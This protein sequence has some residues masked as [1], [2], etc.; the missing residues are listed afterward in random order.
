[1]NI[2]TIIIMVFMTVIIMQL[3]TA[4]QLQDEITTKCTLC[5]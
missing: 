3:M 1:M 4:M 5:K 2:M